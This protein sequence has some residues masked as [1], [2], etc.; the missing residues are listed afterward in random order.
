M[1]HSDTTSYHF[2]CDVRT[3]I[4]SS[5]GSVFSMFQWSTS[6]RR[7]FI[8]M[9]SKR[10]SPELLARKKVKF[11]QCSCLHKMSQR[12]LLTECL[13]DNSFSLKG[14]P[15]K[16]CSISAI[17]SKLGCDPFFIYKRDNYVLHT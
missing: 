4:E 10:T 6:Q 5:Q 2:L 12:S 1:R 17:S 8:R 16:R 9:T 14:S 3:L 15:A 7:N 11:V 13:R